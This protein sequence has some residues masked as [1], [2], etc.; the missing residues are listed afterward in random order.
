MQREAGWDIQM[1]RRCY[2]DEM[3]GE[4]KMKKSNS[5]KKSVAVSMAVA[6]MLSA[7]GSF[8]QASEAK[9][10]ETE[11]PDGW[12]MVTNEGGETL[13]YSPESGVTLIEQDG[14][15]FKDLDKDGELDVYEDWRKD[16]NKRSEDLALKLDAED[17]AGLMIH[18]NHFDIVEDASDMQEVLDDGVRTILS[19]ATEYPVD[20][21]AKWANSMQRYAE[22]VGF[23]I[24]VNIT[25]DPRTGDTWPN[26]LGF[27]ATFD[28]KLVEEASKQ[29]STEYRAL[30]INTLLGPQIDLASEPR[31][32]RISGTFGEDP[33]LT[34]DMASA[35][36]GGYQSTYDENGDDLGW[37][38]DSVNTMVKHWVG[39][40]SAEGGR[41]SHD[42]YGAYSVFPGGQFETHLIPFVDGAFQ[43]KSSTGSASAIMPCYS[44]AWSDDDSLGELVG[45]AFSDYK[46]DLLHAY[47][48][49]GLICSDWGVI[50]DTSESFYTCWGVEDM[51][52]TERCYKAIMAGVDQIGGDEGYLYPSF[53]MDAY[54]M[55]SEEIDQDAML[56]RF[57]A[58]A[59]RILKTFFQTG[60]FDNP[61]VDVAN[62]VATINGEDSETMGY[63]AQLKSVVMLKNA[64]NTI[65]AE[66]SKK[67]KPTVYIPMV[68]T[69]ATNYWGY[70]PSSAEFPI[71]LKMVNRYFNVV[72]DKLSDTLTGPVDE[73]GAPTI[74]YEDII[75]ATPE[76]LSECDYAIVFVRSPENYVAD[77]NSCGYDD[78]TDTFIPISL[79]YGEYTADAQ[80]VRDES[81]AGDMIEKEIA[82]VYGSQH[83]KT[84]ENRG[85]YGNDAKVVNSSDLDTILYATENLPENA[86]VI[87][88]IDAENPM[89]V[90]EF[91]DQVDA[92][93]MNFGVNKQ[94]IMDIITGQF[95]PSGLLP[96]QLPAN[97]ETVEAQLED[98][99]RDMECYVDAA[100]NTYDFAYGLNW[101]GVISDERTETYAVEPL[102]AP[103]SITLE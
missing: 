38:K 4:E 24:P 29:I 84:K 65:S 92:I 14:Y 2:R 3:K 96:F 87:V 53:I 94:A 48:Y 67:E 43:L 69:E 47:G 7:S 10:S 46:I 19:H 98:V 18:P 45:S 89:I 78:K 9:W 90:A 58:S 32:L 8:V 82:N 59:R 50:S 39:E 52:V 11:M 91:E 63:E 15:A 80:V 17:I 1:D 93:L 66:N 22:Q 99:P 97:M 12:I 28:V 68:Y 102:T 70:V 83:I 57:Q 37:G 86:K 71:D 72:T 26:N 35:A 60:L 54:E 27:G 56:E 79:Q 31:W 36:I 40:G 73:N 77:R 64:D 33:A 61:Y 81:I 49:D 75:R 44:I 103:E 51:T 85:Y 74:A 21:Q 55:G 76:E 62:A 30:G 25:T 42:W 34:R 100:G 5:M 41:E 16:A 6:M 20:V 88:S 95:E 101:S 23:G 13:G